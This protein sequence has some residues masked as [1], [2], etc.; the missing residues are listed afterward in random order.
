MMFT[1]QP[2]N[3]FVRQEVD[4]SGSYW[5]I[6]PMTDYLSRTQYIS[7]S[8]LNTIIQ[9]NPAVFMDEFMHPR[10]ETEALFLGTALHSLVLEKEQ[11][12]K[13]YIIY[14]QADRPEPEKTMGSNKNKQWKKDMEEKAAYGKFLLLKEDY[15]VLKAQHAAL[16]QNK[17][18]A[19]IL[20]QDALKEISLYCKIEHNRRFFY[21]KIRPDFISE[22]F[23]MDLKRTRSAHPDHF[24]Y[25]AYKFGYDIK[26]CFY[27]D[28]I[29]MFKHTLNP[30]ISDV[31]HPLILAVEAEPYYSVCAFKMPVE[32]MS[33][34]KFRYEAALDRFALC[35]EQGIWPGYEIY[36]DD[37]GL[38]DL[39][40]SRYAGKIINQTISNALQDV[41]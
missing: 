13:T 14:D 30:A 8:K 4:K 20:K 10:P 22:R 3:D 21:C 29:G 34:G 18:T 25:D 2:D 35:L 7:S 33:L 40:L 6:E 27:A 9:K 26:M 17:L 31:I 5:L 28:L 19:N 16:Q 12:E 38:I 1:N 11:F 41:V 23:F 24:T 15:D 32:T 39:D 37:Q 36:S